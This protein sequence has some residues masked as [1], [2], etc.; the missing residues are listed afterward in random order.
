M[1][2]VKI[3]HLYWVGSK[4]IYN[5]YLVIVDYDMLIERFNCDF[6]YYINLIK[7]I[8]FCYVSAGTPI[9]FSRKI[10]MNFEGTS[11]PEWYYL[12]VI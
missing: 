12:L 5:S 2:T 11:V 8:L 4:Q 3:N 7:N 6:L 9:A 1:A 10:K